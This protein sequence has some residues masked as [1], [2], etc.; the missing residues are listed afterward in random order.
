MVGVVEVRHSMH[1]SDGH[2]GRRVVHHV[3]D[4]RDRAMVLVMR[5]LL[6]LLLLLLLVFSVLLL[7]GGNDSKN[8]SRR[9]S[10]GRRGGVSRRSSLKGSNTR[11]LFRSSRNSV[12]LG[13]RAVRRRGRRCSH[14]RGRMA[15]QLPRKTIRAR[16]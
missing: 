1:I 8:T 14:H 6:L 2:G 11:L 3:R 9:S 16:I 12:V 5:I 13:A 7:S 15:T 10:S 4:D